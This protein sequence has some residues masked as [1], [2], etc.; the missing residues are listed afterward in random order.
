MARGFAAGSAL[1]A[2]APVV[3]PLPSWGEGAISVTRTFSRTSAIFRHESRGRATH[4]TQVRVH[5]SCFG[6]S[7]EGPLLDREKSWHRPPESPSG[8]I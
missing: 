7:N 8:S 2:L 5:S 4:A 1:R 3:E 6:R